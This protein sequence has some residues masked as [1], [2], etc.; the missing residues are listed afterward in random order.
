MLA[1][2]LS[3]LLTDNLRGAP[4][5]EYWGWTYTTV[6]WALIRDLQL[7]AVTITVG[8]AVFFCL[9][10]YL[11]Q[12]DTL[13]KIRARSVLIGLSIPA[14]AG[15]ITEVLAPLVHQ[16]VPELTNVGFA[17][18]VG[19]FIGYAII[20][21]DLFVSN[22]TVSAE[23][24]LSVMSDCLFF[25]NKEG[26]IVSA[27]QAALRLLGFNEAELV[28]KAMDTVCAGCLER[29]NEQAH[30]GA[31]CD[32]I[33]H[34]E[35]D[36]KSRDGKT[37]PVSISCSP[38]FDNRGKLQGYILIARDI[39]EQK[40]AQHA[41]RDS[42][43]RYH[44]LFEM[45]PDGIMLL[46]LSGNIIMCNRQVYQTHGFDR[47]DQLVGKNNLEFLFPGDR[48]RSVTDLKNLLEHPGPLGEG[49]IVEYQL[50]RGDEGY[51]PATIKGSV[52]KGADGRPAGFLLILRDN[53]ELKT[54]EEALR[55]SES[56]YRTLFET[57]TDGIGVADLTGKIL[58][59][60]RVLPA[61]LGY[62]SP[63]EIVGRQNSEFRRSRGAASSGR[64][65][66]RGD[67]KGAEKRRILRPEKGRYVPAGRGMRF[68]HV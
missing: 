40:R 49:P 26:L 1:V 22:P 30:A 66:A 36:L 68:S 52:I 8:M 20:R 10:F 61:L 35:K 9:R 24:I 56:R 42:E 65:H 29:Q 28:G 13:A 17:V 41:I 25:V 50:A 43:T 18:G 19:G 33:S 31:S 32:L 45:S 4:A 16:K 64:N 14:L 21:Y 15:I 6:P 47:E 7:L 34:V 59:C 38:S 44:T 39:T 51:W 63:D 53:T 62:D 37:T 48:E 3:Y 11:N 27:N 67:R 57:S 2:S 58:I 23:K 60:N 12:T 46:D 55:E 5:L 54:A